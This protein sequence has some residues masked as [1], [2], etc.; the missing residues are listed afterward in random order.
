LVDAVDISGLGWCRHDVQPFLNTTIS[1]TLNTSIAE[2]LPFGLLAILN[3][4]AVIF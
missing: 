1:T 3:Q 2:A 4:L